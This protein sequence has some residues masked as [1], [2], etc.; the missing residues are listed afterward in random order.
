MTTKINH[1][2]LYNVD[3]TL[4]LVHHVRVKIFLV[5]HALHPLYMYHLQ[6]RSLCWNLQRYWLRLPWIGNNNNFL[7]LPGRL[8]SVVDAGHGSIFTEFCRVTVELFST[9]TRRYCYPGKNVKRVNLNKK[10]VKMFY[11]LFIYYDS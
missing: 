5:W 4:F 2:L 11:L 7:L 1:A 6:F 8:N 3:S 9:V 10:H